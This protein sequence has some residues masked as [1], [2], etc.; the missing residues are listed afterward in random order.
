[1][2]ILCPLC[3]R[4]YSKYS[5]PKCGIRYCSLACYKL[6]GKKCVDEFY[7]KRIQENFPH[8]SEDKQ[9]QVIEQ[10]NKVKECD[11]STKNDDNAHLVEMA[12]KEMSEQ[13]VM[14]TGNSKSTEGTTSEETDEDSTLKFPEVVIEDFRRSILDGRMT[15]ML[16]IWVPWWRR[17]ANSTDVS[18][19][20]DKEVTAGVDDDA[21]NKASLLTTSSGKI[22]DGHQ[23]LKGKK[24]FPCLSRL[25]P[26]NIKTASPCLHFNLIEIL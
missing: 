9:I 17:Y 18:I 4:D 3:K 2:E 19:G 24:V 16:N 1:M 8:L 13:L 15:R 12:L 7:Q 10:L 25:L 26:L 21:S 6:H 22:E 11:R 20:S 5:C 14:K 23:N